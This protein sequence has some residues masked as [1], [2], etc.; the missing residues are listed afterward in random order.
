MDVVYED[1]A[2]AVIFPWL[3]A[4][5]RPSLD[6][7]KGPQAGLFSICLK[8]TARLILPGNHDQIARYHPVTMH[9]EFLRGLQPHRSQMLMHFDRYP[10]PVLGG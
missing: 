7:K 10:G 1:N 9:H 6:I 5:Y 8:M 2:G 3:I 4:S